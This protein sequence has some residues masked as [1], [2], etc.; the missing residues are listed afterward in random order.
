LATSLLSGWA[1]AGSLEK[2]LL[3]AL[4]AFSMLLIWWIFGEKIY[5]VIECVTECR[6]RTE[7]RRYICDYLRRNDTMTRP[8][9]SVS[10]LRKALLRH[11]A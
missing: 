3:T 4:A 10:V 9:R 7:V 5:G 11:R 2:R 6:I 8:F 1:G